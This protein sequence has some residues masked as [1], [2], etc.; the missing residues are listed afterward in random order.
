MPPKKATGT[1]KKRRMVV[2]KQKPPTMSDADWAKELARRA[3]V[4]TDRQNRR[5]I[6]C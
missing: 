2:P 6:Q 1:L 4:T 5:H 3:V